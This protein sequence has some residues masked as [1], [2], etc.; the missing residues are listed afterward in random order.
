MRIGLSKFLIVP[1]I[2]DETTAA[3]ITVI[4]T[5]RMTLITE[6]TAASDSVMYS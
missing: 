2:N 1:K 3:R 5:M 4:G 6:E